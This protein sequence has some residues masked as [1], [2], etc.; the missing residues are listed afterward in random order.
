MLSYASVKALHIIFVVSWFAALFYIVRLFIYHTEADSKPENEKVILQDQFKIMEKRLWYIIGW[1][2]M[3]LTVIF[4]TWMLILRPFH[5]SEPWMHVKL[6]L[7]VLLLVYHFVI[8]RL[9]NKYKKNQITWSS[10][11]LRL[12]NEVAT[13]FLVSIV[14]VV[15]LKT[16]FDWIWGVGSFIVL[17]V[18]LMIAVKAYK[19]KRG[20]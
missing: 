12:F 16:S 11:K 6:T 3:I 17:G 19:K 4:G 5:F 18:L 8:E 7:V 13:L 9:L 10:I 2:A 15:C 20:K 1:P 14:F